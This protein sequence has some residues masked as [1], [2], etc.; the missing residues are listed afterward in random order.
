MLYCPWGARLYVLPGKDVPCGRTE[1]EG[2]GA[3][4]SR[5]GK[6][7]DNLAPEGSKIGIRSVYIV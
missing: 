2:R 4:H 1:V 5:F 6:K 7:F 3:E